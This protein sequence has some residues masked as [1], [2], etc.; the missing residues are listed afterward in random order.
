M[1]AMT[2]GDPADYGG[3]PRLRLGTLVMMR[4]LALLGQTSAISIV[5][6]GLGLDLPLIQTM[7]VVIAS[8]AFNVVLSVSRSSSAWLGDR[9]G[10]AML[11]FDL[12]QLA[13]LLSLTGGLGNPF[14]LFILG[15]V[16]LAAWALNR[17]H[18]V[19]IAGFA[20][21]MVTGLAFIHLPLPGGAK[22]VTMSP[23]FLV[24]LWGALVIAIL[25]I[26]AYAALASREAD[27]LSEALA[28]TEKA[29]A[30][31][32]QAAAV[33]ALAAAA[34][35]RLG[36]P[37]STIAIAARELERSAPDNGAL[38]EDLALIRGESERCREILTE[39]SARTA[40][41][42]DGDVLL[43]LTALLEEVI[44]PY[45][46]GEVSVCIEA[47]PLEDRGE[48]PP[49]VRHSAEIVQGLSALVQ[50]AVQFASRSVELR[51]DW[52]EE[53]IKVRIRDDGPGFDLARRSRLSDPFYV[54]G[55]GERRR[56]LE[57]Q[58]LGLGLFI[59]R[60]LLSGTGA[61][62]AFRN[63]ESGGAEVE[64]MWPNGITKDDVTREE[65]RR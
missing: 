49:M 35:H 8:G 25:F 50:N 31:E 53:E 38:Q 51:L 56:G 6:F 2:S 63:R 44:R 61:E 13:V 62:L 26:A 43:P 37:L 5:Y 45:D 11:A 30:R 46:K 41:R 54:A 19:F 27:R 20:L 29:L 39:L 21:L 33:G 64:V 7:A 9:E 17:P 10:A 15:P 1:I 4:W 59:A 12:L 48:A 55:A 40:V 22:M 14:A 24:A 18:A 28:A 60:T 58:H 65:T 47:T 3:R 23:T 36:S 52:T 57:E 32:H 42:Q 34:A 16:A